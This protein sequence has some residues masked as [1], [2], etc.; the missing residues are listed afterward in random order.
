MTDDPHSPGSAT[1]TDNDGTVTWSAAKNK[2]VTNCDSAWVAST[3][4][5]TGTSTAVMKE[6]SASC[7][8]TPASGFTTGKMAYLDLGSSTDF[9]AYEQ[10]S[11]WARSNSTTYNAAGILELKLCSDATGDTPVNTLVMPKIY[12]SWRACVMDNGAA[13]SSSVRSIAIYATSDP[14]TAIL[15]LDNIVA[16]AAAGNA[17]EVTHAMAIGKKT[18]G[19]PEWYSILSIQ[20]SSVEIG[21]HYLAGLGSGENG[22]MPYRGT[23]ESVTTYCLTGIDISG[24]TSTQLDIQDSGTAAA[25]IT[26]SGGWD[27]T[28]MSTQPGVTYLCGMHY[29]QAN[30]LGSATNTDYHIIENFGCLNHAQYG[31]SAST[32]CDHAFVSLDQLVGCY[33]GVNFTGGANRFDVDRCHGAYYFNYDTSIGA[34][35]RCN[36]IHGCS[37]NTN[38]GPVQAA[39][40]SLFLI[41]KIDNNLRYGVTGSTAGQGRQTRLQGTTFANNVSGDLYVGETIINLVDCTAATI[42]GLANTDTN[43]R[44]NGSRVTETNIGGDS[45]A[46]KITYP[47]Y[48]VASETS[49]RHTASGLAWKVSPT[50]LS[51]MDWCPADMVLAT[52]AVAASAPVIVKCWARRTNTGLTVGIKLRQGAIPGVT[53]DVTDEVTVAADTWEELSITF[54]PTQAGVVEIEGY[55]YGGTTYSAYFDDLTVTQ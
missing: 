4:I 7:Y 43:P 25:P 45:T 36:R 28:D 37:N 26:F 9:S 51:F 5:T 50:A 15:Y 21:A 3:N 41:G 17:N 34:E 12:N 23:T 27:Q 20:D 24:F 8:M 54:T 46:H 38:T 22:V 39:C 18:A 31:Y 35:Y 52:I 11:L 16:C 30:G 48:T 1:W 49:V 10:I 42:G 13:L 32:G 2:V 6:G 33:Y 40:D 29:N 19:E 47:D 14:G 53:S 55:C 44:R